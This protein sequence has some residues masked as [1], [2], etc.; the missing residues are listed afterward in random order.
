M[1][2]FVLKKALIVIIAF[3]TICFTTKGPLWIHNRNPQT[4]KIILYS[5]PVLNAVFKVYKYTERY[6][7]DSD[8]VHDEYN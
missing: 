7:S 8:L 1:D 4:Q 2:N 5:N 3:D 6:R